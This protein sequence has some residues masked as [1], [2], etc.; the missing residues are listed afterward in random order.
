M[1][2]EDKCLIICD[3]IKENCSGGLIEKAMLI[4]ILD[5]AIKEFAIIKEEI[6]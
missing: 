3:K 5:F 6:E 2:P 4:E 1:T